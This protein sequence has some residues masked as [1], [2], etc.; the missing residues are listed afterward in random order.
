MNIHQRA[1]FRHHPYVSSVA[2]GVICGCGTQG[3]LF[4]LQ[5]MARLLAER[6]S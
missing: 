5:R 3:Y 1:P 2:E 4:A 6:P